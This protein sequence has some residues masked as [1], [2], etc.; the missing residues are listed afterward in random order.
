MKLQPPETIRIL[1]VGDDS[2]VAARTA[3]VL[4]SENDSFTVITEST[5]E[6]GLE[7]LET[8]SI[9]CIVSDYEL[10]GMDGLDFLRAVREVSPDIP[11]IIFTE[12][13]GESVVT[14]AIRAGVTDYIKKSQDEEQYQVLSNRIEDA[15]KH[16]QGRTEYREIFE[17]VPDGILL[18]DPSDGRIIDA[19]QQFAEMLGY[20]RSELLEM[21]FEE[22]HCG[23]PPYTVERAERLVQKA[24]VE[25]PLN[26]VWVDKT[27]DGDR[28][29]VEVHLRQTVIGGEERILAV[30]R[31]ISER[32]RLKQETRRL[33]SAIETSVDGIAI[34]DKNGEYTYVNDAHAE[35]YGFEDSRELLGENWRILY[36]DAELDQFDTE[37][38]PELRREGQWRGELVGTRAD[39]TRFPQELTLTTLESDGLIC[40]VRDITE[41]KEREAELRRER[42]RLRVLFENVPTPIMYGELYDGE[43]DI[44]KINPAF[45][46]MFGLDAE[47]VTGTMLDD[48]ILPEDKDNDALN[49]RIA[50]E[51][52]IEA[53]VR[54]KAADGVR[55]FKLQTAVVSVDESDAE[56]ESEGWAVYTDLTEQKEHERRLQRQHGELQ[57]L[58]QLNSLIDEIIQSLVSTSTRDEIEDIVCERLVDSDI[59]TNAL[60]VERDGNG[61][62]IAVRTN[63][64]LEDAY[65]RSLTERSA[66]EVAE[67]DL[68][69]VLQGG[70][71]TV[72]RQTTDASVSPDPIRGLAL[73]HGY[74]STITVPLS[75]GSTVYGALLVNDTRKDAFSEH[76]QHAFEVLG[77]IVGLT[78]N[79]NKNR[80]MLLSDVAFEL[81]FTISDSSELFVA[82]SD[83]L[84]CSMTLEGIVPI[85]DYMLLCYLTVKRASSDAVFEAVADEPDLIEPRIVSEDGEGCFLECVVCGSSGLLTM[86]EYGATIQSAQFVEGRGTLI[87][88]LDPETNVRQAVTT[89]REAFPDSRLSSKRDV[90]TSLRTKLNTR[91][92]VSDRL[93]DKQWEVLQ[94]AFLSGYFDS[95]RGTTAQELADSLGIAS[96]TLHQHLQAALRKTLGEVLD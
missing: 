95:P 24:A 70:S 5:A 47:E 86:F 81:E 1:H 28:L 54:R 72:T 91:K 68:G 12:P 67:N 50:A 56:W 79:A 25:G 90:E 18:H 48:H 58:N 7:R 23:E 26:F 6:D 36:D 57:A 16:Q 11:F 38:M 43:P 19:N 78:V 52:S 61:G 33:Y 20:S 77:D 74:R 94:A 37:I 69:R 75:C 82:A 9:D 55:D 46:G 89:F 13:K 59:Y 31:D 42:E 71:V 60:I 4:E 88:F 41:R 15:V 34:L 32:N 92:R 21:G 27:K 83:H 63:A 62:G 49:R 87:V 3:T 85:D 14:A 40:V 2:A 39:G 76:E 8:D 17:K 84:D 93:T 44:Q 66:S 80:K 53:E 45:E 30:V 65:V 10:P 35:I 29:P 96:S 64:G 73:S 22:I 51:G